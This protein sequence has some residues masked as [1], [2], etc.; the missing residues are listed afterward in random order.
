MTKEQLDK[1]RDAVER[2]PYQHTEKSAIPMLISHID[3][4]QRKI[5][6]LLEALQL[7]YDTSDATP[8]TA[9]WED[10]ELAIRRAEAALKETEL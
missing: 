9:Q 10:Y 6:R 7:L 1:L 4:Q 2:Y 5:D 8:G 3:E